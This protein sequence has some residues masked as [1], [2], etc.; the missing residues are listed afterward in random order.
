MEPAKKKIII[1][2]YEESQADLK[3]LSD[4]L[5]EGTIAPII[6]RTMTLEEIVQAHYYVEAGKK[7]GNLVIKVAHD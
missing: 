4:L 5:K 1:K 3:Y 7:K 2:K 6:D